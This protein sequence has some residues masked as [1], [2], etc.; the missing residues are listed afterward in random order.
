[1]EKQ[2]DEFFTKNS[3]LSIEFSKYVL[4]HPEI[5]SLLSEETVVV[6]LPEFD[7]ELRDF[8]L[9]MAEELEREGGKVSEFSAIS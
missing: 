2:N 7:P 8:N 6:F 1:M 3:E 4:E 9:R 5:D